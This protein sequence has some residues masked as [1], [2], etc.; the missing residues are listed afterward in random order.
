[1]INN[2]G[3]TLVETIVYTF[4][5]GIVLLGVVSFSL[6]IIG[7]RGKINSI[8]VVNS[9][10]RNIMRV[11]QDE[12]KSAK[13][14]ILPVK[15]ATGTILWLENNDSQAVEY[16]IDD[17]RLVKDINNS[18]TSVTSAATEISKLVFSNIADSAIKDFIR[19]SFDI[20]IKQADSKEYYLIKS[21]NSAARLRK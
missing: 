9:D 11:L 20:G 17:G 8:L 16:Y 15:G 10:T 21:F 2:K 7:F 14:I 5:V 6:L 4:L 1:M 13:N 18:T 19:Y 12:I 3:F